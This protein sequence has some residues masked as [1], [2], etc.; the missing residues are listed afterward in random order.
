[1]R[2]RVAPSDSGMPSGT[3]TMPSAVSSPPC[4]SSRSAP[5]RISSSAVEGFATGMTI[6]AGSGRGVTIARSRLAPALEQVRLQ[7]LELARLPLDAVLR[8][9]GRELAVLDDGAGHTTEV[10]G[11]Q[12]GHE[13]LE[14]IRLLPRGD[15]EVVDHPCP[16][17]VREG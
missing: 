1:W 6:R 17:A 9:I 8:P 4:G 16:G 13:R 2:A 3:S 14:P 5:R 12:R 11:H 10:H 15:D 7:P